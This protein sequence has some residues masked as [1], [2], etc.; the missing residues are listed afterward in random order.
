[1]SVWGSLDIYQP[2]YPASPAVRAQTSTQ[3]IPTSSQMAWPSDQDVTLPL[4]KARKE[5]MEE[6][7]R[8]RE[9]SSSIMTVFM[10]WIESLVQKN[11]ETIFMRTSVLRARRLSQGWLCLCLSVALYTG[12]FMARGAA[13]AG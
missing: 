11:T 2:L 6:E 5:A 3:N 7:T 4:S 10:N 9:M 12:V 13:R 1:M 8:L